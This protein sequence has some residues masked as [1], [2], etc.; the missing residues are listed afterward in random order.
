MQQGI[1]A[2]YPVEDVRVEVY[3]GKTH[4]VDSKEIAFKTAGRLAF[5]DAFLKAKPTIL[6]PIVNVEVTSPADALGSITGDL[7]SRRGRVF[8]TDTRGSG[9]TVVKASVPLAEMIE[10]EPALKSMTKGRGSYTMELSH[11]DPVPER[12]AEELVAQFKQT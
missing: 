5:K 4:S 2:G 7:S 1:V 3:D 9:T 6:E 10:Y 8:G 11:Y 12:I